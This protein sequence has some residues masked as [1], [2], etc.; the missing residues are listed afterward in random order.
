LTELR[1][2]QLDG[3]RQLRASRG[4]ILADP[5]GVG[6]TRTALWAA[7]HTAPRATVICPAV[8]MGHWK[9][10]RDA[11]APHLELTVVSYDRVSSQRRPP[12]TD[13]PVLILD[14]F[15]WCKTPGS[16]RSRF[17][18]GPGGIARQVLDAGGYV[19]PISGTPMPRNPHELYAVMSCI[20]PK[21]LAAADLGDEYK[22]LDR[23]CVWKAGPY[24]PKVFGAKNVD[25]LRALLKGKMIRRTGVTLP[26]LR[27]GVLTLDPSDRASI[28][29]LS[30]E[31]YERLE[32]GAASLNDPN[33]SKHLHAVGDL[34]ASLMAELLDDELRQ[35]VDQVAIFA[36]HLSVLDYL[37][38]KL[39][40]WGVARVD[41]STSL[42]DREA[43]VASMSVSPALARVFL[44]QVKACGT[45]MDGLQYSRVQ[46][47]VVLEPSWPSNDDEQAVG[48]VSR[49]GQTRPVQARYVVMSGTADDAIMR[50]QERE[51][52]MRQQVVVTQ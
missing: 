36:R 2:Y 27:T 11:V 8:V 3:A 51:R 50:G 37:Q 32:N 19:W 23:F 35:G 28:P 18:F 45:G 16:K 49:L 20:W 9:R 25:G 42:K 12:V 46:E 34:K 39:S 17:I 22:W 33:L 7:S 41:G 38:R 40:H 4:M 52:K 43:A 6:K 13:T 48:R 31:V 1:D 5:V 15:H 30:P 29:G 14:E 10:E 47:V 26:P 24:G 21:E 44:G